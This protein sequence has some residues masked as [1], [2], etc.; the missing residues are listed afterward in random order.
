M[1]QSQDLCSLKSVIES[2]TKE[3]NNLQTEL[4]ESKN[5]VEQFRE[6]AK[7]S[8]ERGKEKLSEVNEKLRETIE[9]DTASKVADK[10]L[11]LENKFKTIV[12]SEV[13]YQS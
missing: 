11:E 8:K 2:K 1:Q 10:L 4:D 3:A 13:S 7:K 6:A 5:M 12:P 9:E